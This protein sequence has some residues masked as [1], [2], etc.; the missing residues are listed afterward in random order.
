MKVLHFFKSY[1]PEVLGGVSQVIFQIC[2]GATQAGIESE[3]LALSTRR[4]K[5]QVK[6]GNHLVHRVPQ[7]VEIASTGFSLAAIPAFFRL[8][9]EADIIHYH[10]PWPY[11]DLLHFAARVKKPSVVTYHSDVVKQKQLLKLYRPL[12]D[13]FLASVD[14]IVV[15]SPNYLETSETLQSFRSKCEVIPIGLAP[16]PAPDERRANYWKSR[17]GKFFLFVGVLRYYKGLHTLLE[18]AR[19]V[20]NNI[21]IAGAGPIG[22]ELREMAQRL[23]LHNVHFIGEVSDM[24]KWALLSACNAFVFPSHLRSEAFGISLLEAMML[25]KPVVACEIGTGTTYLAIHDKTGLVVAPESAPQLGAAMRRLDSDTELCNRLG[26][27]G[28]RRYEEVFTSVKMV[29]SYVRLYEAL[30]N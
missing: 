30:L 14:R 21:V 12:Q 23:G 18:A 28:L 2:Q 7:D 13:C 29:Q 10:F 20:S 3:V 22:D 6:V 26:Q 5:D 4:H 11:M 24:D 17:F 19:K 1:Y 27:A 9:A 15:T 16:V 8:S 25:A